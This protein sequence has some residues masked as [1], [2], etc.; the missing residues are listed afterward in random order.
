V[1]IP[2]LQSYLDESSD[3]KKEDIFCV[4]GFLANEQ[5]WKA[6]Q[7]AWLERLRVP[8]EIPYFR[9]TACKGVHEPFFRLRQK[10]GSDA[11]NVADKLRADLESILLSHHWIG[12]GVGVVI[13][14]Y[15]EVWHAFPPARRLY[16]KDPV[17]AAFSQ[18]FYEIARATKSAAP[19]HQVAF[20][21]DDS[22]YS[23]K[24]ADAFKALKIV[25]PSLAGTIATLAPLD[26]KVTPPLQMADLIVSIV[27]DVFLEW[28]SKGKP[29]FAPLELKWH[30]HFQVIGRW[31][32]E[33]MLTAIA[34]TFGDSRFNAGQLPTRPSPEPTGADLKR[35]EKQRRKA[36]IR[37]AGRTK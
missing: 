12:F 6:M 28:I 36:L 33:H 1:V 32:K 21:I 5:H 22:T 13:A 19:E 37:S 26:D 16:R 25:N 23:G 18:M 15:R 35:K 4:G 20:I 17:E 8:D 30:N 14:D 31:D 7:D 11:Q 9:A 24:I 2:I 29:K 10:Y 34:D 27:K 3:G